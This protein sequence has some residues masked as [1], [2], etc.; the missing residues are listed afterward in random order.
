MLPTKNG[1]DYFLQ[2]VTKG[3]EITILYQAELKLKTVIRQEEEDHQ[4]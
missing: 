1:E 3:V 2:G 4:R